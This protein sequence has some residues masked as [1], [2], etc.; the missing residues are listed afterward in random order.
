MKFGLSLLPDSAPSELSARDYYAHLQKVSILAEEIGFDYI[1]MT[2]HYFQPYG[3]YCP[4]PMM[5]LAAVGAVTDRIRLMTGGIQA[6]FHHPLQLAAEAA[7]LDAL[8]NGR[9]EIGFAR[10]F[11]PYE[12][13]AFG[14]D[15][16]SSTERF[17][18]TVLAVV[19]L[20]AEKEASARTPYFSYTDIASLPRPTQE[21]HPPV[22]VAA[23][24]TPES[25]AWIGE[26]GFNLLMAHPPRRNDVGRTR[27]LVEV[28][29]EHFRN[30]SRTRGRQPQVA[31]SVPL[32]ISESDEEARKLGEEHLI[33]HWARFADAARSWSDVSSPAYAGYQKVV[34]EKFGSGIG[35]GDRDY[36]AFGSPDAVLDRI[37]ALH[38]DLPVDVQL[39]Q[40]DFGQQSL[41]LMEQSLNLFAERV[42]PRL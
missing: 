10:A 11:L 27:E 14:V 35:P 32:L 12:F 16:D 39:W 19:D 41:E 5:F 7:E 20:W 36:A 25:F 33:R 6:S 1:K 40:V 28:Y 2:E 21:P 42:L 17:R 37:D 38:R 22:W 31:M 13:E 3:G 15:L 23:L 26:Q 24:T 29:R 8:T 30:S 9:A 4:S 34:T 18:Q